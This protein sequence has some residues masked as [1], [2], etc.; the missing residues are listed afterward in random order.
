MLTNRGEAVLTDF[1]IAQILGSTQLT[2]SGALMGTLNYMA[3]EQGLQGHCDQR[4][5]LYSLGIVYYE[6]LTGYTPFDADTPLAILLKHLN[7]PLPLPRQIDPAL[8]P[9]L[10]R[11]AL[12]ALSKDPAD[13]YQSAEEMTAALDEIKVEALPVNPRELLPH[14]SEL[15][16]N[17]VFSGTSRQKITDQRFAKLDTDPDLAGTLKSSQTATQNPGTGSPANQLQTA[18]AKRVSTSAAVLSGLSVILFFNFLATMI[19]TLNGINVFSRGWAF[20]LFLLG[21]FLAVIMWAVEIHWLLIPIIMIFGITSILAYT[22]ITGRWGDWAFLWFL[23]LLIIGQAIIV[24]VRMNQN[25]TRLKTQARTWGSILMLLSVVLASLT[26]LLTGL[27]T[28]LQ[29][30]F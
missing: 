8:P 1:G 24:P 5:D 25:P 23:V 28:L 30:A 15:D 26:C 9:E 13:R 11:I 16:Q 19:L 29:K 18:P 27:V 4:S 12:R 2:V 10:E 3:P 6:M 7:D 14:P 22:A 21:G 17:A 20:E